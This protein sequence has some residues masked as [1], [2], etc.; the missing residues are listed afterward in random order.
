M[1]KLINLYYNFLMKLEDVCD[2]AVT[3][4]NDHRKNIDKKYWDKYLK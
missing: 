1:K 2:W 3:K 4:V